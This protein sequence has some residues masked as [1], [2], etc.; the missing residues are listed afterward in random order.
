[1]WHANGKTERHRIYHAAHVSS[2]NAKK[3][4]FASRLDRFEKM[5]YFSTITNGHRMDRRSL[6][7]L[8]WILRPRIILTSL[9]R[10]SEPYAEIFGFSLYLSY[11]DAQDKQRTQYQL[12]PRSK[13]K[14]HHRYQK[15]LVRLYMYL[16]T[17]TKTQMAQIVVQHGFRKSSIATLLVKSSKLGTLIG[18][19]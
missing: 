15:K 16:G 6:C 12:T 1:M 10:Q 5:P 8:G 18:K 17:S 14:M 3:K 4:G 7:T 2:K 13:W 11:H 9:R 19:P